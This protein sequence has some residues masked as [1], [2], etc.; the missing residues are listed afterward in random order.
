MPGKMTAQR[1]RPTLTLLLLVAAAAAFPADVGWPTHGGD[2]GHRQHS[3]LTQINRANVKS[4]REAWTYHSGGAS[5]EGRTQIQCNPIVVGG[6]L[7]GTSPLIRVFA[8]D[9]A[10]GREKWSFDLFAGSSGDSQSVGVNRG[11]TY[12]AG[13]SDRRILFTAGSNLY[14][15]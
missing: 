14:A 9:A 4:L 7:Y 10:T 1:A 11:V 3:S 8:L 12:W 15:L 6:V 2:P 13:G 5:A